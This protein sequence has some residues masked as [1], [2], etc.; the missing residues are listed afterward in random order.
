MLVLAIVQLHGDVLAAGWVTAEF[1]RP[2]APIRRI[3][4]KAQMVVSWD[5]PPYTVNDRH[6][7]IVAGVQSASRSRL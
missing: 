4:R 2:M 1:G 5:D 6:I 3:A 7:D